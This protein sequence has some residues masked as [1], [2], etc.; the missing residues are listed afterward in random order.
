MCSVWKRFVCGVLVSAGA[1]AV[2]GACICFSDVALVLAVCARPSMAVVCAPACELRV[3][4]GC[5]ERLT[6]VDRHCDGKAPG[7]PHR[8]RAGQGRQVWVVNAGGQCR[9]CTE[10]GRV[11]GARVTRWV[12][13]KDRR[14][15]A[16]VLFK[17]EQ[18]MVCVDA[19]ARPLLTRC[20]VCPW[21]SL[22]CCS[23]PG[24]PTRP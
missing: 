9:A 13:H 5:V 18:R 6:E 4:G 12:S 11:R 16:H 8:G 23:A 19:L 22:P 21:S 20:Q 15:E 7:Q 24:W 10:R 2:R 17:T 14:G 3:G 1:L